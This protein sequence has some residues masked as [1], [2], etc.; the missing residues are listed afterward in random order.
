MLNGS[1]SGNHSVNVFVTFAIRKYFA[2]DKNIRIIC[3][4]INI[5]IYILEKESESD[6]KSEVKMALYEY[7]FLFGYITQ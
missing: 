5:L 3:I 4:R 6:Y 7:M 2:I 1:T